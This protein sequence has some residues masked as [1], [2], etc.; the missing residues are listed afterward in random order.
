VWSTQ[1]PWFRERIAALQSKIS[2]KS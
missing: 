2:S 1:K